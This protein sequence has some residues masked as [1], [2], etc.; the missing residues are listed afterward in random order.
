MRAPQV[1]KTPEVCRVYIGS[2]NAG[3]PID[4]TRN[5]ECVGLF[6]REHASL[7]EDLSEVRGRRGRRK[8]EEEGGHGLALVR[9]WGLAGV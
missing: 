1:F 6:E 4:A 7:L 3:K 5:P 9:G 2:F 8:G